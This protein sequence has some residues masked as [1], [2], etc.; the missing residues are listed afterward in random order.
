MA[1]ISVFWISEYLENPL[2]VRRWKNTEADTVNQD[3]IQIIWGF[4]PN[5][6]TT[7]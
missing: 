4:L 2:S 3:N 6:D 1:D 5:M 7:D